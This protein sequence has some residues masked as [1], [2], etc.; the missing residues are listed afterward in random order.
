M[1]VG[2]G[3]G[4]IFLAAL[5]WT[6]LAQSSVECEVCVDY[7]G[8]SACRSVAASDSGEAARQAQATACA[9]LSRGVTQGLECDRT[10]P[11]SVRC[12]EP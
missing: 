6:T 12:S 4:A 2:V 1:W 10:L 8:D 7:G 3:L 5:V 11:R 9:I